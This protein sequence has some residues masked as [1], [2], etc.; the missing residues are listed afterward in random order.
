MVRGRSYTKPRSKK[1]HSFEQIARSE[2]LRI[3]GSLGP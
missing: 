1:A 3:I 2:V